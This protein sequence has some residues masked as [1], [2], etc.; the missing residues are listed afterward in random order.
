MC[1]GEC[2][3]FGEQLV[4]PHVSSM[5][6]MDLTEHADG[7]TAL[8]TELMHV[9][10]FGYISCFEKTQENSLGGTLELAQDG[11][12]LLIRETAVKG[13]YFK[14]CCSTFQP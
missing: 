12:F 11:N 9:T 6:F 3:C 13:S 8:S 1:F 4:R 5:T 7:H 14:C 2:C 10:C